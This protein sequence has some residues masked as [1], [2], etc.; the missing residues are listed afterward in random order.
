[1]KPALAVGMACL[2][3]LT[4]LFVPAVA[5]TEELLSNKLDWECSHETGTFM[6]S[7]MGAKTAGAITTL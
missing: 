3:N 6:V 2:G 1:M 5:V 4:L 7:S